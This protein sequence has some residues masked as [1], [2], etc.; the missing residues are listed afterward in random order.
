M[1]C[2]S[3]YRNRLYSINHISNVINDEGN[4]IIH[5]VTTILALYCILLH[6]YR[7][8]FSSQN[9]HLIFT[10]SKLL[11][12]YF[13]LLGDEER[14]RLVTPWTVCNVWCWWWCCGVFLGDWSSVSLMCNGCVLLCYCLICTYL[15]TL[16][17]ATDILVIYYGWY[18]SRL[19]V[20][21]S[22]SHGMNDG[23]IHFA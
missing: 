5:I 3:F 19:Y 10:L 11:K 8:F 13:L 15:K 1:W 18:C 7:L 20:L 21:S 6:I 4:V 16:A 2:S 23:L 17:E 12:F 14:C 22:K 9:S